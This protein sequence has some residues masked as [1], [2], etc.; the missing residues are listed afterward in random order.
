M[1]NREGLAYL[2]SNADKDAPIINCFEKWE[3]AFQVYAGI[4]SRKNLHHASEIFQHMA[5]IKEA[6]HWDSVY[7]YDKQFRELI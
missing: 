7:A 3:Q 4:Y 1:Y 2:M 6:V 5:N